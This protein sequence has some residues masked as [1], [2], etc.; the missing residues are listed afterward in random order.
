MF[1]STGGCL[2]SSQ[3]CDKML[4]KS[5]FV[6]PGRKSTHRRV[7]SGTFALKKKKKKRWEKMNWPK[8]FKESEKS[9]SIAS[10]SVSVLLF[11]WHVD[12]FADISYKKMKKKRK[13]TVT[14]W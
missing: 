3:A 5:G 4:G 13:K 7:M 2:K 14:S 12:R 9:V 10:L 8:W 6:S 11:S 1:L